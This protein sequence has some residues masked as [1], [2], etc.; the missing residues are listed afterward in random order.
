MA[1]PLFALLSADFATFSG[2]IRNF[3]LYSLTFSSEEKKLVS[4]GPGHTAVTVIPLF[5]TSE[6][7]ARLK[8][9]TYALEDAYT[10]K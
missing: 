1:F 6:R 2:E 4:T 10:E 8:L 7:S 3:F 5:L 9:I